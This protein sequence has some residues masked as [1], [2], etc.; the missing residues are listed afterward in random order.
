MQIALLT[1]IFFI[2]TI[3]DALAAWLILAT[4]QFVIFMF[5]HAIDDAHLRS[6]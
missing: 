3:I 2:H 1:Y 5:I 6:M 4:V